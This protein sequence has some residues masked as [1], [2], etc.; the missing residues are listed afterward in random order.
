MKVA[1]VRRATTSVVTE[2]TE[3]GVEAAAKGEEE[4][5]EV[6]ETGEAKKEDVKAKAKGVDKRVAAREAK[7]DG[8]NAEA[9]GEDNRVDAR[10]AK[11]E[12]YTQLSNHHHCRS[13]LLHLCQLLHKRARTCH[14]VIRTIRSHRVYPIRAYHHL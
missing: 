7:K 2:V 13:R 10:G 3:E 5:E 12:G 4:E 1:V 8:V 11:E 14:L 9:K 6:V